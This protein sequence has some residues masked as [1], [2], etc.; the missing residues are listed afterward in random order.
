MCFYPKMI[1]HD[2]FN[3][4]YKNRHWRITKVLGLC[5]YCQGAWIS[6]I[7]GYW[8]SNDILTTIIILGLSYLGIEYLSHKN[9]IYRPK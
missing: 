2:Y 1:L 9:L 8:Y 7:I 6:I 3:W 5:H 4:L